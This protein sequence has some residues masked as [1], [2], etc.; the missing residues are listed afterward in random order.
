MK[1][2]TRIAAL[3]ASVA[4]L[5]SMSS[6]F[7]QDY[8]N[9]VIRLF[10]PFA[11]GGA[12]DVVARNL[13][14][15]LSER[16]GQS[17]IVENRLGAGGNIAYE[18]VARS[19][20]DGYTLLFASTGIATNVSLYKQLSYDTMRDFAPI[21]LAARSPHVLVSN[22][23]LPASN[24]Q[25]LVALGKS[26]PG[27]LFFGSSGTGTIPHLAGEMFTTKTG[28]KLMHVPY[29]GMSLAQTDLMG[30]SIQ[31]IFSDIPSALAQVKAGKLRAY[32]VTG[33]QRSPSMPDV[34]TLAEAGIPGYA[35][36]AWFGI[37]APAGTP[38]PV[39]NRLNRELR[40]I[41]AEP[42]LKKKML[43]IGQELVG[44]SPQEFS[45]FLRSE[46]TKMGEIVR[47]SGAAAN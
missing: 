1:L 9:R 26:K 21:T 30:G 41:L 6:A 40:A 19:A 35:I 34:P 12:P 2:L 46:I 5:C 42:E 43:D 25:E 3:A 23:S 44:D 4:L 32:G 29:K 47:A 31:L 38:A 17:V 22:L 37:L 20:P 27:T 11:T 33:A 18:A 45:A 7:A 16:L 8:P 28:V 14:Q 10:V 39:V 36:D 13:A 15:K 24:V